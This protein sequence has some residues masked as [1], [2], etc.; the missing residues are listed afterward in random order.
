MSGALLQGGGHG[1]AAAHVGLMFADVF[2]CVFRQRAAPSATFNVSI[3]RLQTADAAY[4]TNHVTDCLVSADGA[5]H[6]PLWYLLRGYPAGLYNVSVASVDHRHA[7]SWLLVPVNDGE[8]TLWPESPM[9]A[10]DA[11]PP[12]QVCPPPP[13]SVPEDAAVHTRR[14]RRPPRSL[15]ARRRDA[16]RTWAGPGDGEPRLLVLSTAPAEPVLGGGDVNMTVRAVGPE[17]EA[18]ANVPVTS[19]AE[20]LHGTRLG[21]SMS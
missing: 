3:W 2:P 8:G 21:A 14:G 15:S 10:G 9:G 12:V 4:I 17:G 20:F 1:V 6:A 19:W 18:V 5:G 13:Q 7:T 11:P 16:T